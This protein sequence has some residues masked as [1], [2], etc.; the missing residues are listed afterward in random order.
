MGRFDDRAGIGRQAPLPCSKLL[1]RIFSEL[2]EA[3]RQLIYTTMS[4]AQ[5]SDALGFAEPT[6]LRVSSVGSQAKA[7]ENFE[8]GRGGCN[9]SGLE[10]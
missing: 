10:C 1:D 6:Y 5:I 8:Q 7:H 3:K 2:W 9:D 4:V